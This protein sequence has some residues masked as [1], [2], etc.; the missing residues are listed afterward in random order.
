MRH[1][2]HRWTGPGLIAVVAMGLLLGLIWRGGVGMCD[3]IAQIALCLLALVL[4]FLT[5]R[6]SRFGRQAGTIFL[7]GFAWGIWRIAYFDSVTRN[8]IPGMGYIL[9]AS[10]L[11]VIAILL[12]EIRKFIV[13]MFS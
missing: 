6:E 9:F 3:Y 11:T 1:I 7:T 13:R 4:P 12:F 5:P 8:A 10:M 2:F